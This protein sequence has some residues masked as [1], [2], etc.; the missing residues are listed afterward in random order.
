[1]RTDEFDYQLPRELIA[2]EPLTPRDACRLLVVHR[3]TG[4]LEHRIFRN[5]PEY[6]RPGD[7]LV[8]NETKVIPARLFG[9]RA[10]TGGVVEVLLLHRYVDG[11]V[12]YDRESEVWETLVR[13]GRQ[14]VAGRR[15]LF[16]P[17][18]PEG[19]LE[20]EVVSRTASGGALLRFQPAR[21]FGERLAHLG[22]VPLPPYIH[23][24]LQNPEEYQTVYARDAGS[25]AAPTAGLHFTRELLARIEEM[26]VRIVPVL[27]HVG[28]DTFRPVKEENVE[29][30]EMHSEFYAVR[31]EAAAL[32]NSVRR[33][34]G[35]W[36]AVGT[37]VTR[38][39]ESVT[40]ED[41]VIHPGSGWTDLFIVPGYRFRAV[42]M[43]ITN[44]HLPQ[45]TLLMLVTALGGR[46]LIRRAYEEAVE[47][48]YRF[49]S[50]GDAMLI[51]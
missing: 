13:P 5:L 24:E 38:V 48:R 35:R 22:R 39:L 43:L 26:G 6:L 33:D 50:F 28:L 41:G 16:G 49:F 46:E 4:H 1:M 14:F 19:G 10:D 47:Q 32:L 3:D 37:T 15:F 27:L 25:A 40:D 11:T 18:I 36:V 21:D 44:F 29:D 51:I 2:Q 17:P 7:A 45:S 42:D 8:I 23:E 31:P 34:G 12:G 30:H 9:K 20:A